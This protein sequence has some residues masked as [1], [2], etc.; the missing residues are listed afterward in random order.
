MANTQVKQSALNVVVQT[1]PNTRV[2]QSAIQLLTLPG[3]LRASCNNPPNGL[4][5]QAY[6]QTFTVSGGVS[7]YTWTLLSGTLPTGLALTAAT[8]VLSG[9]PTTAGTFAFTL[10]VAD[11]AGATAQI[12]CS[13]V[14]GTAPVLS[15][16]N[17]PAGTVGTFYSHAFGLS[18][19][20]GPYTLSLVSGSLPPGLS[21]PLS[22]QIVEGS[23]YI[24][25][26]PFAAGGIGY[27][28]R[29]HSAYET[30]T[31]NLSAQGIV[32]GTPTSPGTYSFTLLLTDSLGNTART[33]C[34]ITI[35]GAPSTPCQ[36]GGPG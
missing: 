24:I 23:P 20:T 8:G 7:P 1:S 15:C 13:I 6:S 28:S 5:S 4:V 22:T 16:N 27:A 11:S 10:Q 33:T 26:T 36:T 30:Q 31:F 12:S 29:V 17:P 9:F 21:L 14:I 34:S 25:T 32:E 2:L 18:G 3:A 35:N 19:G